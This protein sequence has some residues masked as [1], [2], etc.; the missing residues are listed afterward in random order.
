MKLP[1]PVDGKVHGS[2]F[3]F[4]RRTRFLNTEPQQNLEGARGSGFS[5]LRRSLF[6]GSSLCGSSDLTRCTAALTLL[7]LEPAAA[8]GQSGYYTIAPCKCV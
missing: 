4:C 8:A 1:E 3:S 6:C 7:P 2:A 5:G